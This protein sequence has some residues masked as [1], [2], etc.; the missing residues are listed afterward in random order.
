MTKAELRAY[1]QIE[2]NRKEGKQT[3]IPA[4]ASKTFD[5]LQNAEVQ[6]KLSPFFPHQVLFNKQKRR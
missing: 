3:M 6:V 5:K 1:V 4:S 2:G